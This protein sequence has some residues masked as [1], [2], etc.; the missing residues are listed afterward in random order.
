MKTKKL[1]LASQSVQR[2]RMLKSARFAFEV[3]D[4]SADETF[5]DW[6]VPLAELTQ[7]IARMKMEHAL[8]PAGGYV[9]EL[10]W[11]L[12]AD[13]LCADEH[14]VA[15]GKPLNHDDAVR[16]VKSVRDGVVAG[17][18]FCLERKCW[19]GVQWVTQ[20]QH[21]EYVAATCVI[22]IPDDEIEE[23]F[24]RLKQ[25]SGLDYLKLAGS[26]SITGYGAQYLKEVH[27]SYT[28]ILGLPMYEVRRALV[29]LG[30]FA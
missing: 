22:S 30:Y 16:M 15:F 24:V 2:G 21:V 18:G 11:V 10:C 8:V 19:N 23:Y 17:T 9:G 5:C 26:F 25:V 13:S 29:K 6:N 12:A 14:G 28:A 3:I 20:E 7:H 1:Y 27:G 4:Q